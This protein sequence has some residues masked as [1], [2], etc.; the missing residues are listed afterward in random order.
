MPC[1]IY[2]LHWAAP[3]L[4]WNHH[5]SHTESR[6]NLRA[7]WCCWWW[8]W[9]SWWW[10]W[11]IITNGKPLRCNSW[12]KPRPCAYIYIYI[13]IY[14]YARFVPL[15]SLGC[16]DKN[17]YQGIVIQFMFPSKVVVIFL[18]TSG[19]DQCFFCDGPWL[20]L[21]DGH[22]H[23]PGRQ[24]SKAIQSHPW[25]WQVASNAM[26]NPRTEWRF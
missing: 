8:W 14:M 2:G 11:H 16:W 13:Y 26:E 9:W 6:P 4:A 18:W 23:S 12:A 5:L 15:N 25:R 3:S 20:A 24:S 19:G 7:W 22:L 17:Q 1:Q 21:N 10:R